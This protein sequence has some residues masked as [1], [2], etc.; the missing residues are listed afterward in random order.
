MSQE[1]YSKLKQEGVDVAASASYYCAS[2]S[3][4]TSTETTQA[5]KFSKATVG[6]EQYTI[7][8]KMPP[9]AGDSNQWAQQAFSDPMPIQYELAPMDELIEE[10]F[11]GSVQSKTMKQAL[12]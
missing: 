6:T 12:A 7:G 2:I 3:T 11:P 8:S 9:K 5:E 1:S 4:K 10:F